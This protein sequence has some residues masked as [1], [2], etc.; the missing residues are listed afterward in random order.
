MMRKLSI[1][2]FL[3]QSIP[4]YYA[5]SFNVMKMAQGFHNI[6]CKVEVITSENANTIKLKKEIPN[7]YDHYG[8]N[9]KIS[10]KYLSPSKEAFLN[11]NTKHD[12]TF[13]EKACEY[14]RE[15]KFDFVY[16][17]NHF[18]P[19]LTVREGIPTL[20][21][22]HSWN[23]NDH[24]LRKLDKLTHLESF[25]GLVTIHEKIKKENAKRGMPNDK[26]LVLED[27]VDLKGFEISDDRMLWRERLGLD[28]DKC[29]A[30]YSGHLYPDKGI[31]L[32]LQ[33]AKKLQHLKDLVFLLVGGF[34][35][36]KR[37]WEDYCKENGI[38]NVRFIG[39]VPNTLV[40]KYLKAAD[41]LLLA[42]K[43]KNMKYRMIDIHT[44]SPLKLFEY[45]ASKRPIVA[46][47]IPT[48]SKVL[49][50]ESNSLLV[51]PD[52]IDDFCKA[53][54]RLLKDK[55]L[56]NKLSNQAYYEVQEYTWEKRCK[57]ILEYFL[58]N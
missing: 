58:E 43:I 36:D 57:K 16:C 47:D 37:L 21:E 38:C 19:Y 3:G 13:C 33:A 4:S 1:G 29:Y 44:T 32:I 9:S 31:E 10:I 8:I 6:G 49:V 14:A 18:L 53:I 15:K 30:V 12:P 56:S 35:K 27:G 25:K 39:F 54:K 22:T 51:R 20:I 17:R 40:P 55:K 45:M 46:T 42:Y 24:L 52:D 7:I 23:Y 41:C 26:I 34:E 28:K 5:H 2:L 48:I 11:C 50:H